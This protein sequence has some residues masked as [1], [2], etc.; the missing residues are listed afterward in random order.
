MLVQ[1]LVVGAF[2]GTTLTTN[3]GIVNDKILPH[4][5]SLY[6]TDNIR[7]KSIMSATVSDTDSKVKSPSSWSD[8]KKLSGG[9]VVGSALNDAASLRERGGGSAFV[10]SKLRLFSSSEK[11]KITLYRDHAGCKLF[12]LFY[13]F[14]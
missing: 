1:A 12:I 11:P 4:P 2:Q 7:S 9:S 10:Q 13:V 8:L 6:T 14:I 5:K 3:T